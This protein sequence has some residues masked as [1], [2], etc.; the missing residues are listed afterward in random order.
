MKCQRR[1]RLQ[2]AVVVASGVAL[3]VAVAPVSAVQPPESA[4]LQP[5]TVEI[6]ST[7]V[8]GSTFDPSQ[9]F[10]IVPD[11]DTTSSH[12]DTVDGDELAS[13]DVDAVFAR[14]GDELQGRALA[15]TTNT[16][17]WR[18]SANPDD[19][20]RP[21]ILIEADSNVP[22]AVIDL[23]GEVMLEWRSVI[24]LDIPAPEWHHVR[25]SWSNSLE[26]GVLGGAL[27]GWVTVSQNGSTFVIPRFLANVNGAATSSNAVAL[28]MVLNANIDWDFTL[29]PSDA[30][31]NNSYYLK[32]VLL[33]EVGHS[34]GVASG[35]DYLA[36]INSTVLSTWGA[37][38][39]GNRSQSNPFTSLRSSV[40]QTNNLWSMNADG[41]WEKIYDPFRW[42][43][44]SSLSHLDE[45]TY[46]Y[47]RAEIRT[48]GALMTP[49]L[50]NGEVNNVDGVIAGLL[51]QAGYETFLSPAVPG[52]SGSSSGGVL[53]IAISPG[54][55]GT[56]NVPAK[57]WL[58]TV[59][60]PKGTV[61]RTA[62]V[63]ATQRKVEFGGFSTSGTYQ[64]SV[65]AEIDGQRANAPAVGVGF[66]AVPRTTIGAAT[67]LF[68]VIYATDYVGADADTL[69]LYRAFF[70]RDPDLTGIQYW[71]GQSRQGVGYDDMAWA[72]ANSNEFT[73]RYQNL[74]D[75]QFLQ[76]VYRNV[77][78]RAPDQAGFDYW[79]AEVQGGLA[80][81][82][83]VRWI[84]GST[85]FS[86]RHPY[87]PQ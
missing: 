27:T 15:Q 23:M 44:G 19:P 87:L 18:N 42:S 1:T 76:V 48:P 14:A 66:T 53:S 31:P 34:L 64:V 70:E 46:T 39:F 45:N 62:T 22:Q 79:Y 73:N 78:G 43:Q 11:G 61:V 68:G 40:V 24:D 20:S 3:L 7:T 80:R 52:V 13:A 30:Q 16:F 63:P 67:N 72:F 54:I 25:I 56:M 2:R 4:L 57:Q 41:T 5:G 69:R 29:D 35:A 83:A 12:V 9:P 86:N 36:S 47:R 38:F 51:S 85:E 26:N 77:L 75:Q 8:D 50:T 59:R 82:L 6:A 58:V 55:G 65:T 28:D 37:T 33:H 32:T 84:A 10:E 81:H 71:I 17:H 21:D 60:N 49:I 74:T